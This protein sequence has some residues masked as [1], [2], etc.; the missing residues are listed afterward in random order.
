MN[1]LELAHLEYQCFTELKKQDKELANRITKRHRDMVMEQDTSNPE[2]IMWR[3]LRAVS[4]AD[5]FEVYERLN[6]T[7][8]CDLDT[9]RGETWYAGVPPVT[10]N[11]LALGKMLLG[12][13]ILDGKPFLQSHYDKNGTYK[14]MIRDGVYRYYDRETDVWGAP[15]PDLEQYSC[16]VELAR[17]KKEYERVG[18]WELI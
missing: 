6:V 8:L 16:K 3:I 4:V 1:L 11:E 2:Y 18:N 15:A 17:L 10:E 5:C 13:S 7:G 12:E 14:V 9:V